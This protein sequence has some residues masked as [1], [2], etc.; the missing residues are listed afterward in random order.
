[1]REVIRRPEDFQGDER[2]RDSLAKHINRVRWLEENRAGVQKITGIPAVS[3]SLQALLVTS[4]LMPM[5]FFEEMNFPTNQVISAN[6]LPA[7]LK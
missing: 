2:G 1:V 7:Y 5:Q 3:I 4:E 6:E